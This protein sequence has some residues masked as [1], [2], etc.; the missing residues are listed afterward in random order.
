MM[1]AAATTVIEYDSGGEEGRRR[2]GGE[3]QFITST[4]SFHNL[5]FLFQ[6]IA[7]T[8]SKM[9][10]NTVPPIA[11]T[12][13]QDEKED[14]NEEESNETLQ[15]GKE[16]DESDAIGALLEHGRGKAS[17]S[18]PAPVPVPGTLPSPLKAAVPPVSD[19]C[20]PSPVAPLAD[21][22]PST[23]PSV[24]WV[25][26]CLCGLDCTW[27]YIMHS[28]ASRALVTHRCK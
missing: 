4:H 15:K 17:A 23:G 24:P 22:S 3:E 7:T 14:R 11:I 8:G 16:E 9:T 20:T 18:A 2:G 13:L 25:P 12:A 6:S 28:D 19:Q 27:V 26:C 5:I 10:T 1:L 21:P